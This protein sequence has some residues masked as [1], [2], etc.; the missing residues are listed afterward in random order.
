MSDFYET[1]DQP[2]EVLLAGYLTYWLAREKDGESEQDSFVA[3]GEA[4]LGMAPSLDT[5]AARAIAHDIIDWSHS[6]EGMQFAD[7]ISDEERE[8]AEQR[9]LA[10]TDGIDFGAMSHATAEDGPSE[11]VDNPK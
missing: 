2:R 5:G 4:I 10:W 8:V 6:P 11:L 9:Y 1:P 3:A 7:G